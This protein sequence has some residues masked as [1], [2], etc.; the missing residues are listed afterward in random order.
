M[1][2]AARAVAGADQVLA[3]AGDFL[4]GDPIRHNLIVTLLRA[5]AARP[6]PAR[7]WVVEVDGDVAG[8][9]FQ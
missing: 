1:A 2:V 4:A 3:A 6:E 9:V 7:Y 5:R 8:V